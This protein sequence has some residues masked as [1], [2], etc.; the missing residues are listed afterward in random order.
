MN[1]TERIKA[2]LSGKQPDRIPYSG[3]YHVPGKDRDVDLFVE[4][5]IRL[6]DKFGWDF[7]KVMPNGLHIS[8]AYGAVVDFGADP[9]MPWGGIVHKYP[10]AGFEDLRKIKPLDPKENPVLKREVEVVRR[11]A[12]HYKGTKPILPTM[13]NSITWIQEMTQSTVASRILGFY[14]EHPDDLHAALKTLLETNIALADAYIE[15]GADGIFLASQY[16]SSNLINLDTF[17]ELNTDYDLKLLD[18]IKDRTW[19]N[20]VHVH[21]DSNLYFEE[22]AKYP[23]QAINWENASQKVAAEELTSVDKAR[24]VFD[25]VLITGVDQVNDFNGSRN[26]IKENLKKR[27]D[28]L[29]SQDP[30]GKFIFAPGCALPTDVDEDLFTLFGEVIGER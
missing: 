1:G 13:F 8:E 12:E 20:L 10:I 19:F 4:E 26:D 7:V 11:L 29:K 21:G 28:V 16:A 17:K 6:T 5:T 24:S 9:D 14:A 30:S 18:H 25:G 22:F 3:W 2:L 27:L 23:V 15:A